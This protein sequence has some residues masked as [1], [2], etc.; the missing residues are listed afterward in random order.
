MSFHIRISKVSNSEDFHNN[1]ESYSIVKYYF[2]LVLKK[3]LQGKEY[4][5]KM[6]SYALQ[7]SP[8]SLKTVYFLT[9]I[10]IYN[11]L[12]TYIPRL[13]KLLEIK[14]LLYGFVPRAPNT[15]IGT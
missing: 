5:N 6:H 10:T 11:Y 14:V 1:S 12:M 13:Y 15:L 8:C 3:N 9:S 7:R 4:V 2:L